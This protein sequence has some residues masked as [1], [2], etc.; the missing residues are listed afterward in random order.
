M[1]I[2]QLIDSLESGGAE[3]MAVNLANVL[4]EKIVFSGLIATRNEGALKETIS[5][6]VNYV[7]LNKKKTIDLPAILKLRQYVIINKVEFIHAHSSSFFIASLLKLICPRVKIIWHD[8]YGNSEFLNKRPYFILQLMSLFFFKIIVVNENL[9]EWCLKK[10]WCKKII[11][12]PNFPELTNSSKQ[13]TILKGTIGKRI[14]SLANLRPQKNHFLIIEIAKILKTKHPDWSFHL[15][16]KDFKDDYSESL[17]KAIIENKLEEIIHVYGSCNDIAAILYQIDI[18]IITSLSEGLPVA[19]LEYGNFG[20]PVVSSNV[21]DIAKVIQHEIN[22]ILIPNFKPSNYFDA[23]VYLIENK[24]VMQQYGKKIR[25]EIEK[26]FTP[27]SVSQK[28]I[29]FINE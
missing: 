10:L 20:I 6:K 27:D 7:F 18:G 14:V 21:G 9:K 22:G 25:E 17:K 15:I 4:A 3:R 23:L 5:I 19:L 28:Y 26:N 13:K 1:R 11:Y 24:I 16:G 29:K 2:L 8:H 12:L